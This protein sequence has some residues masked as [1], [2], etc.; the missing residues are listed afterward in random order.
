MCASHTRSGSIGTSVTAGQRLTIHYPAA[1]IHREHFDYNSGAKWRPVGTGIEGTVRMSEMWRTFAAV[2]LTEEIRERI[3][4]TQQLLEDAGWRCRWV[5][6]ERMHMTVRFYGDL[7]IPTVERLQ[8]EL[9][10]RLAAQ[11]AFELRVSRVGAFPGPNRPRTLWLGIDDRF[12]QL[13]N[14][15]KAVDDASAAAGIEP[16]P[17]PYRPHLTV[18]RLMHNFKVDEDEAVEVFQ[19]FG[20][21][22]P[23]YWVPS[24]VNLIR[25]KFGRGGVQYTTIE[26]FPLG[27]PDGTTSDGKED[28]I[29]ARPELPTLLDYLDNVDPPD[30]AARPSVPQQEEEAV[31]SDDDAKSSQ[32]S[33]ASE[34]ER[35]A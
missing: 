28:Q 21:Y 2:D 3:K 25:S 6:E 10:Q 16:E 35:T 22:E 24:E 4:R 23:L 12:A 5:R 34:S 33:D 8:D 13:G 7:A 30:E 18:G 20:A 29:Y 19:E 32:E 17:G 1:R 14:L 15:R 11:P 9:R 27:D 31:T 26:S